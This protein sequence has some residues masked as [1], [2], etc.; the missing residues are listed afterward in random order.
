M[1]LSC[2]L[3]SLYDNE[4]ERKQKQKANKQETKSKQA[5]N[6]TKSKQTNKHTFFL[7]STPALE[8]QSIMN[9]DFVWK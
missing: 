2:W 6:K 5:R 3:N 1:H 8:G 4:N 7:H 9:Y